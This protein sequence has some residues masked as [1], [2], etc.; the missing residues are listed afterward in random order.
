MRIAINVLDDRKRIVELCVEHKGKI[1]N[2]AE[3]KLSTSD[4]WSHNDLYVEV[5]KFFDTLTD[6]DA[7][8]LFQTYVQAQE[9]FDTATT[10]DLAKELAVPITN[11]V[12]NICSIYRMRDFIP[13]L[14][15][16]IPNKI[17]DDFDATTA[18][19]HR[20]QTYLKHEYAGLMC[21][22]ATLKCAYPIW[23]L[24]MK[25]LD[26]SSKEQEIY[27]LLDTIRTIGATELFDSE[28]MERLFE[29]TE[30][31]YKG[32][33]GNNE[34]TSTLQGTGPDDAV[35]YVFAS[36]LIDKLMRMPINIGDHNTHLITKIYHKIEQDC[37]SLPTKFKAK[38]IRREEVRN[39]SED[40]KINWLDIFTTKQ[41]VPSS[42][43][44]LNSMYLE[45]YEKARLELDPTIPVEL[46]EECLKG[47]S[48]LDG[49]PIL[50]GHHKIP[51]HQ[52]LVQWILSDIIQVETIPHI[53]RISMLNAM[54]LSQAFLIH[55]GLLAAA[56]LFAIYPI[57]D[58]VSNTPMVHITKAL[59]S[60]LTQYCK[61]NH[62]TKA[63][64]TAKLSN[65]FV[66][67]IECLASRLID[68]QWRLIASDAMR[69]TL[70]CAAG[71]RPIDQEI[72]NELAAMFLKLMELKYARSVS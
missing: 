38:V 1:L 63:S 21:L 64:D 23:N 45:D 69:R 42:Y 62:S 47:F 34:D 61:F 20:D 13:T 6:A 68:Y 28:E 30:M 52:T 59:Q 49:K 67:S 54:A 2:F 15:I 53:E 48:V 18:R 35:T 26:T 14:G 9:I 46:I 60:E 16:V 22:M 56:R 3:E 12:D 70:R 32:K 8:A 39:A 51:L 27:L 43:Y 4:T 71:C 36:V 31:V 7:D 58:E 11:I 17:L 24:Y 29:F 55:H 44:V 33:I 57:S 10:N 25:I 19:K 50:G 65:P 66:V 5:N 37:K 41:K 40:S 72:K